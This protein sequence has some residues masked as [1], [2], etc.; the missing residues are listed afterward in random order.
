MATASDKVRAL[1]R[2]E[3]RALFPATCFAR[4]GQ[5]MSHGDFFNT[6]LKCMI[7]TLVRGTVH[8]RRHRLARFSGKDG[9]F[10]YDD[11]SSMERQG[12]SVALLEAEPQLDA[13][14]KSAM[15]TCTNGA[16]IA[17]A[18]RLIELYR[19]ACEETTRQRQERRRAN[20][21]PAW[22]T[23]QRVRETLEA[24]RLFYHV[25]EARLDAAQALRDAGAEDQATS[26]RGN[27][28]DGDR[29]HRIACSLL[30]RC[31]EPA[32]ETV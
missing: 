25:R 30:Q 16:I 22:R 21:A 3:L 31:F 12:L 1:T 20:R 5:L 13:V 32:R 4:C 18:R 14:W 11:F 27:I 7:D 24:L 23:D 6:R 29:C 17:A 15:E 28:D 19:T 2:V 26:L 10:F 8:E 9:R